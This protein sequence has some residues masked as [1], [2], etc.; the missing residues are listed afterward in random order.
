MSG[1]VGRGWAVFIDMAAKPR[2]D[3]GE[4][5]GFVLAAECADREATGFDRTS[6]D[7]DENLHVFAA[8]A[9]NH[10][11]DLERQCIVVHCLL[12]DPHHARS[13]QA[14]HHRGGCHVWASRPVA[15]SRPP[16]ASTSQAW[17]PPFA[18][19]ET[20]SKH[21]HAILWSRFGFRIVRTPRR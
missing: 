14:V 16:L 13:I 4:Q 1:T 2:G 5:A 20:T 11:R 17:P 19:C 10:A 8:R 3:L 9:S 15:E 7:V 18:E 6:V 12:G 21:S